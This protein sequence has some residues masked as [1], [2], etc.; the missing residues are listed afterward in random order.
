MDRQK[1]KTRRTESQIEGGAP[2]YSIRYLGIPL[3]ET[4]SFL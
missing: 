4:E 3:L 1:S 2:G